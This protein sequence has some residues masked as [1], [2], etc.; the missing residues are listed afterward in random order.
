MRKAAAG[1]AAVGVILDDLPEEFHVIHDLTTPHGNLDHVV[2]GPTGVF[3]IDTKS[4]RGVVA[5]DGNGELLCNGNPT[6]KREIGR[7]VGRLM[8]IKERV[9]I[10][11]NCDPERVIGSNLYS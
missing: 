5:A 9:K 6:Q 4:W 1:E 10:L 7:F 3:I 8:G 11:S 2:V